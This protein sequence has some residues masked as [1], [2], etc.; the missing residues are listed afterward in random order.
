MAKLNNYWWN[1]FQG[2]FD[3]EEDVIEFIYERLD[4]KDFKD[5]YVDCGGHG[6][7]NEMLKQTAE[8]KRMLFYNFMISLIKEKNNE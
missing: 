8:D 4:T 5:S 2:H 1:A 3:A 6:E 7:P